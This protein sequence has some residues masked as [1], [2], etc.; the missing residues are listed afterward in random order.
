MTKARDLLVGDILI[1]NAGHT[2]IVVKPGMKVHAPGTGDIVVHDPI[3]PPEEKGE[4]RAFRLTRDRGQVRH[5]AAAFA[6]QWSKPAGTVKG[7]GTTPY[8][9]DRARAIKALQQTPLSIATTKSRPFEFDALYRA[10]KWA[11]RAINESKPFSERHG[12]TCCAFVTACYHAA[13]ISDIAKGDPANIQITYEYL[14]GERTDKRSPESKTARKNT[15]IQVHN[16]LGAS[17][18]QTGGFHHAVSNVGSDRNKQTSIFSIEDWIDVALF[19]LAD[20]DLPEG[21]VV[22]PAE[23]VTPG[24]AYD[25]KFYFSADLLKNLGKSDSGWTAIDVDVEPSTP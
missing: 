23:I 25:A 17:Y 15:E 7:P 18:P 9:E 11:H 20:I 10:V 3:L 19:G 16:K 5:I 4:L 2:A 6:F 24:L 22:T 21:K 1:Y 8:S 12:T 14:S 13:F